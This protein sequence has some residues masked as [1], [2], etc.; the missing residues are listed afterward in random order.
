VI[1]TPK[2]LKQADAI[3]T[4]QE[5]EANGA[6]SMQALKKLSVEKV[7]AAIEADAGRVLP[8]LREAL[9]VLAPTEI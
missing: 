2:F 7:A 8:G 3:W 4:T 9:A 5:R 1:A 6:E